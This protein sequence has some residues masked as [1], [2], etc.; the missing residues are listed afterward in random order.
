VLGVLAQACNSEGPAIWHSYTVGGANDVSRIY[1]LVSTS[2]LTNQILAGGFVIKNV[3]GGGGV[4]LTPKIR[5]VAIRTPAGTDVPVA[6]AGIDPIIQHN[7]GAA[8]GVQSGDQVQYYVTNVPV[9]ANTGDAF[10]VTA[11]VSNQFTGTMLS[12]G[13][14]EGDVAAGVAPRTFSDSPVAAL[15]VPAAPPWALAVLVAL[16]L[17]TGAAYCDALV[18]KRAPAKA[19]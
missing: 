16:L 7:L 12:A 8:L 18:S 10:T 4:D 15:A 1:T 6:D 2:A 14:V 17:F 9:S 13:G 11:V 3:D 5:G 19:R